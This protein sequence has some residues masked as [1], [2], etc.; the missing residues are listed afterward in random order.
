MMGG[1]TSNRKKKKKKKKKKKIFTFLG[2]FRPTNCKVVAGIEP[3]SPGN[4]TG[5]SAIDSAI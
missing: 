3:L 2:V 1:F 5:Y 4:R